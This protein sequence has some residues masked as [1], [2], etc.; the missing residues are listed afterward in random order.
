MLGRRALALLLLALLIPACTARANPRFV[1]IKGVMPTL[2]GPTLQG[3]TLLA[4]AYRGKVV[5]INFWASWCDPCRREQPGLE[6]LWR[7]LG[8]FGKVAFIGVDYRDSSSAG[9]TYLERFG[10]TYPSIS[11]PNGAIG[12]QFNVPY[13]PSTILVDNDG[14]LHYR[15]VGAQEASFVEGLMQT[16]GTFGGVPTSEA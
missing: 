13:L 6:A 11:D 14:H 3:G 12:S 8:P 7:K 1:P 9:R 16:I 4:Q 10:V 5:L 15:L 2:T